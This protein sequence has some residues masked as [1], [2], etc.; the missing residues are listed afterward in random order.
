MEYNEGYLTTKDDLRLLWRCWEPAR[1]QRG[2]LLLFHGLG[3]H[4]GRYDRFVQRFLSARFTVLAIDLRG[5]GRSEGVRGHTP[6]LD[7]WLQDIEL[8]QQQAEPRLPVF[9]YG[10]SLGGLIAAIHGVRSENP[11]RGY[12][13]SAPAFRR[14]FFVPTYKIFLARLFANLQPEFSQHSGLNPSLLCH[15]QDVVRAYRNDPLV[16]DWATARLYTEATK[17]GGLALQAAPSFTHPLLLVC[18]EQDRLVDIR[19]AERFYHNAASGDKSM[20][21]W[22]G[23]YHEI[24]HEPHHEPI[25]QHMV[26]WVEERC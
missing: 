23:L 18:G 19:A 12:V 24:H 21:I 10:H 1:K 4:T 26:E 7:F 25:L 8:L 9:I 16:H 13:L 3:E 22:P 6:S 14:V 11:A 17:A 15:D 2:S 5:H 20:R